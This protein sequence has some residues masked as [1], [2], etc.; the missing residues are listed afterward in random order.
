MV[1]HANITRLYRA[2]TTDDEHYCFITQLVRERNTIDQYFKTFLRNTLA[3][4]PNYDQNN[5]P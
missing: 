5:L 4:L 2:A 3:Y 1:S